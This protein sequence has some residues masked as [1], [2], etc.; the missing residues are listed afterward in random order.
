MI[1]LYDA[2]VLV[3]ASGRIA[4]SLIQD[5]IFR[6]IRE[7]IYRYSAPSTATNRDGQPWRMVY[8]WKNNAD[9]R[10][11]GWGRW[12]DDFEPNR[13]REVG[14]FGELASCFYCMSFWTS[15]AVLVSYALH[16]AGTV[17]FLTLFAAWALSNLIA[18][19]LS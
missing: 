1:P 9:E 19:A 17:G 12:S 2:A 8:S 6:P 13:M 15:A 14:F 18:K 10:A 11:R 7:S 3:L 16:P 5:E 4:Y